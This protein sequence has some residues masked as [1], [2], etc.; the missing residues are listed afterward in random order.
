MSGRKVGLRCT[1]LNIFSSAE[2]PWTFQERGVSSNTL[3]LFLLASEIDFR[4]DIHI[5]I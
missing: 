5:Y 1:L 4:S 2:G 3:I